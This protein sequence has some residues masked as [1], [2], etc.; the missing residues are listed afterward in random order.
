MTVFELPAWFWMGVGVSLGLVFGS[1][2]NVVIYRL[3]RGE[4]IAFPASHCTSCGTPIRAFDNLPVLGWLL[5]RGRARCCKAPISPRYPLVELLGGLLGAALV[6]ATI[7]TLPLETPLWQGGLLFAAELA[8]GLGLIAA[9]FIDLSHMYLPDQLTLGGAALG[10]VSVPLRLGATWQD[11]LLGAAVGF[12]IIWL[13]FDWLHRLLRGTPGM[14]LGDAK[15]VMLAGAWFGWQGAVFTLLAGAVQATLAVVA[16]YLVRGRL[17]EPDAVKLERAE[18]EAELARA[19]PEERAELEA[20]LAQDP[21]AGEPEAG[22]GKARIAFGPFL[23]LATLELLV[24]GE[25]IREELTGML[26][27]S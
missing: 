5:L 18:I 1:F 8:L 13:P 21:L 7:L 15:L 19:T 22:F 3:P 16:V 26:L 20:E 10:L 12:A 6:Q 17:D 24:F 4:S 2:L 23:V 27:G 9:A 25:L 14:G 11:S